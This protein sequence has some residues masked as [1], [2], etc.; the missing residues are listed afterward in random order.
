[1]TY[2]VVKRTAPAVQNGQHLGYEIPR[3]YATFYGKEPTDHDPFVE[4]WD[5]HS[6]VANWSGQSLFLYSD[7]WLGIIDAVKLAMSDLKA[8]QR[9]TSE[10]SST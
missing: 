1:M 8:T 3:Y 9:I 2:R 4:V 5:G 10:G 7:Q 6:I